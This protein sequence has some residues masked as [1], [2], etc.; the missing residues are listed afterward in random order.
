MNFDFKMIYSQSKYIYMQQSHFLRSGLFKRSR[1]TIL[2]RK[3][4]HFL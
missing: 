4:R 3:K 1:G 2:F